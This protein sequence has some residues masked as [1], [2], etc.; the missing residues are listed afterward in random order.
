MTV[1]KAC[2]WLKIMSRVVIMIVI[3][4]RVRERQRQRELTWMKIQSI[5]LSNPQVFLDSFGSFL[6]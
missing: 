3:Y 2:R 5:A 1:H 4:S 6:S